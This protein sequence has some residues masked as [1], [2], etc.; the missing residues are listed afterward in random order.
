M[1]KTTKHAPSVWFKILS[2][3]GCAVDGSGEQ[4]SL[5]GRGFRGSPVDFEHLSGLCCACGEWVPVPLV[6]GTWLVSDPRSIGCVNGR[7]IFVAEPLV[8]P[9]FEQDGV[10]WVTRVRL[11]REAS[12]L[13]LKRFGIHRAIR[14]AQNQN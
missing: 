4:W 12:N 3:D 7:R 13:D 10:I 8:E 11:I 6:V 14:P 1:R 2:A 9:D 5:P